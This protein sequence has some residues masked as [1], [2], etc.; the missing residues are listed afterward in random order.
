LRPTRRRALVVFTLIVLLAAGTTAARHDFAA[1]RSAE[2]GFEGIADPDPTPVRQ[3]SGPPARVGKDGRAV[4]WAVG[5]GDSSAAAR[6]LVDR[7]VRA[8]PDLFLYLGDVYPRGTPR[9]FASNFASTYGRLARRTAP[10][11]GNHDWPEVTEGYE[12]YWRRAL[13]SVP[14]RFYKLRA[15]GW[16]IL[17]LNS[18]A[19]HSGGSAQARWLRAR[20]QRPGTCRLAFWHRPR[21]SAGS[22]HGD[23]PDIE[24]LWRVLRGH[25]RIV[26]NG[27]EHDSQRLRPIDGMTQFVAGA[28]G[29]GLYPVHEDD[30][31]LAFADDTHYAA[32]RLDL[33][34]RT[35]RYAF[36]TANGRVEDSG[37]VRCR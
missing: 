36:V 15:P 32:L 24:P 7:I 2:E 34:P 18:E 31:R 17:A 8:R 1:V 13:G 12:P 25:A 5:D 22:V 35:A 28:G 10:T 19:P 6:A 29:H 3:P 11:P 23:Q 21:L 27:H 14:A 9:D 4:V 20:V 33:S 30:Q 16:E 37:A 26:V